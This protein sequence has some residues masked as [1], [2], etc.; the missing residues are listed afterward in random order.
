MSSTAR[1]RRFFKTP[2]GLLTIVLALLAAMAAPHEGL[3][4]VG[5]GLL[6][7]VV[8]AGLLDAVIL[9]TRQPKWHFPSGAVPRLIVAMV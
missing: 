5:P 1:V 2:K 7:A 8:A 3:R 4:V 6:C 9:R